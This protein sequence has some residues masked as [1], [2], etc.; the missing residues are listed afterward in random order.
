V[1]P[2]D[3]SKPIRNDGAPAKVAHQPQSSR[4]QDLPALTGV[5]GVAACVVAVFHMN[6]WFY[7]GGW[8]PDGP[9]TVLATVFRTGYLGV[10]LFFALSGY[11]IAGAY[12]E[13]FRR[14]S[15]GAYAHFMIRRFAR[16]WP[17]HVATLLL[18]IGA[19]ACRAPGDLA[20]N[21]LMVQAWG[22][23]GH[24]TCNEPS[25]SISGEWFAYLAFPG[26]AWLLL[27]SERR[28]AALAL[29]ALG[30]GGLG[31]LAWLGGSNSLD[32]TFS[33]GFVRAACGFTIGA[34]L[35]RSFADVKPHLAF[36]GCGILV[37]AAVGGL[38]MAGAPDLLVAGLFGPLV[39]CIALAAGPLRAILG[40]APV[41]WLGEISY[42]LYLWH[43]FLIDHLKGLGGAI[44]TPA[45]VGLALCLIVGVAALSRR[46]IEQ[47]ARTGIIALL[48]GLPQLF[49]RT[50]VEPAPAPRR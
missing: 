4:R 32:V 16:I 50:S 12:L 45:A 33:L 5:R 39:L 37:I 34:A 44:A 14:P 40:A 23:I 26:L 49:A 24:V 43:H 13:A 21:L 42:S 25:W 3:A 38:A 31:L 41:V 7:T 8:S 11:V 17:L 6:Y 22:L 18:Y 19:P 10:D 46:W 35:C 9:G 47:P 36:D 20:G 1:I 2:K 29:A 30:L 27:R 48:S 15:R 28:W